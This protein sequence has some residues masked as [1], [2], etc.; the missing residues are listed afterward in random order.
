MRLQVR[1][2]N[3][4][5]AKAHWRAPGRPH[6]QECAKRSALTTHL[7]DKAMHL[8]GNV[9]L[10]LLE[11]MYDSEVPV[12]F[13]R[14]T[15][16]RRFLRQLNEAG[17]DGLKDAMMG[18]EQE[19]EFLRRFKTFKTNMIDTGELG[20]R[21]WTRALAKN[22]SNGV[23][24]SEPPKLYCIIEHCDYEDYVARSCGGQNRCFAALKMMVFDEEILNVRDQ[25]DPSDDGIKSRLMHKEFVDGVRSRWAQMPPNNF[26]FTFGDSTLGPYADVR[27][28]VP[29]VRW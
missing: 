25:D 4:E 3:K 18:E 15:L 1:Y 7:D 13:I 26:L 14:K 28:P 21:M 29:F 9:D 23:A 27:L 22:A 2:C 8:A 6:K 10:Q 12:T 24:D 19:Q 5:C 11:A 16:D 20:R 17:L